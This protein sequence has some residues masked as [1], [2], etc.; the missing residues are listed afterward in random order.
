MNALT[1]SSPCP[2]AASPTVH[3]P[4]P[5]DDPAWNRYL[6]LPIRY[7]SVCEEALAGPVSKGTT[8]ESGRLT[9]ARLRSGGASGMK[10]ASRPA[11]VT[12]PSQSRRRPRSKP[13]L[14][15]QPPDSQTPRAAPEGPPRPP[16]SI[17]SDVEIG[18]A[19]V[20]DLLARLVCY[21]RVPRGH[22]ASAW[23][24]QFRASSYTG[25]AR[26]GCR[27]HSS[28]QRR[29]WPIGP[30]EA[31]VL[32]P[33]PSQPLRVRLCS[34]QCRAQPRRATSVAAVFVTDFQRLPST[35]LAKAH[36]HP[37]D[38]AGCRDIASVASARLDSCAVWLPTTASGDA[39]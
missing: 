28:A 7:I 8:K 12:R 10:R 17:P 26:A 27:D 24:V 18:C 6:I 3:A 34:E 39:V 23:H 9:Y 19:F 32:G 29:S 33:W 37:A 21:E 20:F 13:I 5:A 11:G 4:P 2:A 38:R 14:G 1:S 15:V 16:S 36:R 35:W 22:P 25:A 30:Q 31:E